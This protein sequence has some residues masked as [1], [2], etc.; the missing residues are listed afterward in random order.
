VVNLAKSLERQFRPNSMN[1]IS[2]AVVLSCYLYFLGLEREAI[3]LLES[4]LYFRYEDK[5][6]SQRHLWVENCQGILLLQFI[7][8]SSGCGNGML[9]LGEALGPEAVVSP[10]KF[11]KQQIKMFLSDNAKIVAQA[12]RETQK[13]RCQTYAQQILR[14]IEFLML[15]PDFAEENSVRIG[16]KRVTRAQIYEI[17]NDLKSRL[18]AALAAANKAKQAG[19]P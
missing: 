1:D 17:L 4:F 2:D 6:E 15:W 7:E 11:M 16:F 5:P 13:Y 9:S 3:T 18:V 8:Q 12:E 19:T 10:S 14:C